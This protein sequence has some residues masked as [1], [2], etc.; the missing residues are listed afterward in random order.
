MKGVQDRRNEKGMTVRG[1][2]EMKGNEVRRREGHR[3]NRK[4]TNGN[5]GHLSKKIN[6]HENSRKCKLKCQ[7]FGCPT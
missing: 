7:M 6:G 3:K 2:Q 1:H 4:E 5:K